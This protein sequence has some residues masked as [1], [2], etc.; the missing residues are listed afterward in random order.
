MADLVAEVRLLTQ[1]VSNEAKALRTLINGN[2]GDLSALATVQKGNLVAAVNELKAAIDSFD[3]GGVIDDGAT[4][5]ATTWS[6]SKVSS[7][8]TAALD[9]LVAGAPAALDT[10]NEIAT[11][12]ASDDDALAAL[13]ASVANRV[14]FDAAQGLTAPQQAQ[15]R[16][17]IGAPSAAEVGDLTNTDFVTLFEAGLA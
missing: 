6:S 16:A 4:A 13:T 12:L 11:K 8:I 17:N 3:S 15:A 2:A 10:L 7:E 1:R 14:R 5:T 9:A